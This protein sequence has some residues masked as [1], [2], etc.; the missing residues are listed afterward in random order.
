MV[1]PAKAPAPTLPTNNNPA[2]TANAPTTPPSGAHHGIAANPCGVGNGCGRHMLTQAS[3]ATIGRNETRLASQGFS[4]ETRKVWF[5]GGPHACNAP[6][7]TMIGYSQARL[8]F[9]ISW[10]SVGCRHFA[11]VATTDA[12]ACEPRRR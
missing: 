1:S 3:R 10:T 4:S 5:I 7:M 6:A 11:P 8:M 12:A 2:I 9:C